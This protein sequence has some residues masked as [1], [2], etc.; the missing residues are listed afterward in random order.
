MAGVAFLTLIINAPTTGALVRYL[1]LSRQ[2]DI[3]KNI[4]VSISYKLDNNVDKN[5]AILKEKR[6]YNNVDWDLLK[7]NV[8]LSDL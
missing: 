2:S 8:N 4:L 6:H 1:G 5:I 7:K 3:K